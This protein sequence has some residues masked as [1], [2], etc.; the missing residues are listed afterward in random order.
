MLSGGK[1][2]SRCIPAIKGMDVRNCAQVNCFHAHNILVPLR[3]FI[4]VLD[5]HSRH[6]HLLIV[7]FEILIKLA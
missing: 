1:M 5:E 7:R 2:A 4:K 6:L 3:N